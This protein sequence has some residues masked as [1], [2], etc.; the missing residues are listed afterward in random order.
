MHQVKLDIRLAA[1]FE[2]KFIAVAEAQKHDPRWIVKPASEE[3][4]L[5][6]QPPSTPSSYPLSWRTGFP[7]TFSLGEIDEITNGFNNVSVKNQHKTIYRGVFGE[8][9]VIVICFNADDQAIHLKRAFCGNVMFAGPGE[10]SGLGFSYLWRCKSWKGLGTKPRNE[11]INMS[12]HFRTDVKDYG[13]LLLEL[14]SGQSKRLFEKDGKSLV[15]WVRF[16]SPAQ[17]N[18]LENNMLSP[19]MDPRLTETSDPQ[20]ADMARA[21]LACLKNDSSRHLTI[22]SAITSAFVN[23]LFGAIKHAKITCNYPIDHDMHL[24]S[25]DRHYNIYHYPQ[26]HFQLSGGTMSAVGILIPGR[27]APDKIESESSQRDSIPER[28]GGGHSLSVNQLCADGG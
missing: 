21:A 14:I 18:F 6:E 22:S 2:S 27:L 7:R 25:L 8:C 28:L 1:G 9:P 19:L 3:P 16:Q 15:D 10:G 26:R 5:P 24:A 17:C 20:A 23:C 12:E 13:V 4:H 11:N